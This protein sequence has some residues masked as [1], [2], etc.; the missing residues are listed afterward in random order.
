MIGP[1]EE[2]DY[3]DAYEAMKALGEQMQLHPRRCEVKLKYRD[4]IVRGHQFKCGDGPWKC[5]LREAIEIYTLAHAR[6]DK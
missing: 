1:E 3:V 2:Q 4:Y 5:T 6:G